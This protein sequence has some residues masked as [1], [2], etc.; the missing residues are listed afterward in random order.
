MKLILEGGFTGM[1]NYVCELTKELDRLA[2]FLDKEYYDI[3][4]H[5]ILI[6]K[7]NM[8]DKILAIRV[9]GGTVGDLELNEDFTIKSVK[10]DTNYVVKTYQKNVNGEIQ[11]FVGMK[12][13]IPTKWLKM[14]L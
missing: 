8:K 7:L 14:E 10:V 13:E 9:P 2:D 3:H 4:H 1:E 12:L 5:Y 11:K 6:D